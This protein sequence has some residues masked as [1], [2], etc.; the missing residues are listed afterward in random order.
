MGLFPECVPD[1]KKHK[2]NIK[3]LELPRTSYWNESTFDTMG[4][5]GRGQGNHYNILK[6]DDI[7]GEA[8]RDSK[9]ERES[10]IQWFD[11]CQSFLITPAT[12][13]IRIRGTRWA[14]DDVYAH[15]MDTYGTN[16]KT[17]IRSVWE[18][19]EKGKFKKDEKGREIPIFPE[20]FT[21]E[22]LKILE[23]NKK[24][25]NAQYINDPKEGSS[26]FKEEWKRYYTQRGRT[27]IVETIRTPFSDPVIEEISIEELD[28]CVIVDPALTETGDDTGLVVTGMDRYERVFILEAYAEAIRPEAFCNKIFS[29]IYKWNPRQLVVEEVGFSVLYENWFRAEMTLRNKRFKI[30]MVKT[31]QKEKA[32]RVTALAPWFDSGLIY[33][34][35]MSHT[36]ALAEPGKYMIKLEQEYDQFGA[37]DDYHI[38]DALA[39]GPRI[40]KSGSRV[41]RKGGTRN[42]FNDPN[43]P[44]VSKDK[45]D[46]LTGYSRT[47]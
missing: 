32:E 37:S 45:R 38:L 15:A 25:W 5:S 31:Q 3:E 43:K 34:K 20:Q 29:L 30:E 1:P 41:W 33:F 12:D 21:W 4:V 18:R 11:N 23:K 10:R 40:G 42:P 6:L 13:F 47:R 16:L 22:S 39:M 28:I 19:D 27:L 26:K 2:I 14:F 46:P 36:E 17:F 8:A 35:K 7:Y 44:K 9:T 24:V